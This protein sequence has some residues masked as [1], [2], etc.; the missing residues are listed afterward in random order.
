M[1]ESF[2]LAEWCASRASCSSPTLRVFVLAASV[3]F[4][5]L[6][7]HYQHRVLQAP[8]ELSL[9]SAC[10][11]DSW[12]TTSPGALLDFFCSFLFFICCLTSVPSLV[13]SAQL[14]AVS[15]LSKHQSMPVHE[16]VYRVPRAGA[17]PH[18][19]LIPKLFD[20]FQSSNS[21]LSSVCSVVDCNT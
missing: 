13:L 19:E 17:A 2:F 16:I 10:Q 7:Q 12:L 14:S 1:A 4:S 6:R 21:L 20:L 15:M 18:D 11:R 3:A 9:S 5:A 8:C